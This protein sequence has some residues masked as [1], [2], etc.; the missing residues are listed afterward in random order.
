MTGP[1]FPPGGMPQAFMD[2]LQ[3]HLRTLFSPHLGSAADDVRRLMSLQSA[4]QIRQALEGR[5]PDHAVNQRTLCRLALRPAGT[6]ARWHCDWPDGH[7]ECGVVCFSAIL[8]HPHVT[9]AGA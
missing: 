7:V 8:P 2:R 1:S 4:C 6:V 3:R 5:P 9:L